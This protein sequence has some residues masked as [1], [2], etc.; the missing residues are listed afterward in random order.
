[1]PIIKK[2]I[3]TIL[4]ICLLFTISTTFIVSF[5]YLENPINEEELLLIKKNGIISSMCYVVELISGTIA[6]A[7]M[8]VFIM[9]TG[10]SYIKAMKIDWKS[11]IPI[12]IATALI[13]GGED[14]AK[15]I[16]GVGY[17]CSTFNK[18]Y[19]TDDTFINNVGLCAV[20]DLPQANGKHE[21][22]K[23]NSSEDNCT[24]K[25]DSNTSIVK[26]DI[27][28]LTKCANGYYMDNS[29]NKVIHYKC[30]ENKGVGHWE[31]TE[32]TYTSWGITEDKAGD[33]FLDTNEGNSRTVCLEYCSL[34]ELKTFFSNNYAYKPLNKDGNIISTSRLIVK[35]NPESSIHIYSGSM[36][37]E[38]QGFSHG[39][40]L[41]IGCSSKNGYSEVINLGK[42]KNG[43]DICIPNI[44]EEKS[45]IKLKCGNGGK[46]QV[47]NAS[48]QKDCKFTSVKNYKYVDEWNVCAMNEN[49]QNNCEVMS[50]KELLKKSNIAS[51]TVLQVIS[52][53][54]DYSI[55]NKS[56]TIKY[57]CNGGNWESNDTEYYN[58]QNTF[59]ETGCEIENIPNFEITK[60]ITYPTGKY[61][62]VPSAENSN[63]KE[64]REIYSNIGD[65]HIFYT[66]ETIRIDACKDNAT[67][68][69]YELRE[70]IGTAR[71]L[72]EFRC[73]IDGSWSMINNKKGEYCHKDCIVNDFQ[74]LFVEQENANNLTLLN[75]KNITEEF[76]NTKMAGVYFTLGSKL[77]S[78]MHT[79][80]YVKISSCQVGYAIKR[81]SQAS[82]FK[83]NEGEIKFS[84][85]ARNICKK[86]C[87]RADIPSEFSTVK[88]WGDCGTTTYDCE[89]YLDDSRVLYAGDH[90]SAKECKDGYTLQIDKETPIKYT[91]LKCNEYGEWDI[92]KEGDMC[93]KK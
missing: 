53:S 6:R 10:W 69:G 21:W 15:K 48:C 19:E 43:K 41:A 25:I 34:S 28:A 88:S 55:Q 38:N 22:S 5:A 2:K 63:K 72:A 42:D 12:T 58:K 36:V 92:A 40:E 87:S 64:K 75:S 4:L 78:N 71:E 30:V 90:I 73:N 66:N 16:S 84:S 32:K 29:N 26:D 47:I 81:N 74:E 85:G 91:V 76:K 79:G 31:P 57:T 23:C 24:Q 61:E 3:K 60:T 7:I 50:T 17:G 49:K 39:A 33:Y 59:C 70:S 77:N 52:C 45:Q 9:A 65:K 68:M 44:D 8:C 82:I 62:E 51:Q 67:V 86:L 83:C 18:L 56:Q 1:M 27:V 93:I 89:T 11:F 37:M 54:G 80:E 20:I 14:I 13:F 46:Y 35:D